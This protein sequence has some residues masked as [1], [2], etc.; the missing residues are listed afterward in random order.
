MGWYPCECCGSCCKDLTTGCGCLCVGKNPCDTTLT[1][2]G[3]HPASLKFPISYTSGLGGGM[4]FCGI[5][6]CSAVNRSTSTGH[7]VTKEWVEQERLWD[8]ISANCY[9]CCPEFGGGET[10]YLQSTIQGNGIYV[11]SRCY[12]A[13]VR[14]MNLDVSIR[15]GRQTINGES[16][17]GVYVVAKLTFRRHFEFLENVCQYRYAKITPFEVPCLAVFPA[18]DLT[19]RE[20]ACSYCNPGGGPF[21]PGTDYSTQPFPTVPTCPTPNWSDDNPDDNLPPNSIFCLWRSKFIPNVSSVSCKQQPFTVSLSPQ[22]NV[23]INSS[24]CG[25][26]RTFP[27]DV[28]YTYQQLSSFECGSFTNCRGTFN[29]GPEYG[30]W[31]GISSGPGFPG[32]GDLTGSQA[33]CTNADNNNAPLIPRCSSCEITS[34]NRGDNIIR[35][36]PNNTLLFGEA[37]DQWSLNILC[38]N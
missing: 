4:S 28:Y 37:N 2:T 23:L 30:N 7:T 14:Y 3:N 6:G 1:I 16:V 34:R 9:F 20:R 29:M 35:P 38:S 10:P 19:P 17:C 36:V 18:P 25:N 11:A 21:T 5:E 31:I 27:S 15:Q 8:S 12:K 26:T 33:N 13:I 24:C 22:D 32:F